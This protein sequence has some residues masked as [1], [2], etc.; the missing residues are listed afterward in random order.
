MFWTTFYVSRFTSH[1]CR[2]PFHVSRLKIG[3]KLNSTSRQCFLSYVRNHQNSRS[4]VSP[5]LPNPGVIKS[6]L[7]YLNLPYTEDD[8]QNEILLSKHL[9]YEPMF[10]AELTNL[11][12]NWQVDESRSDDQFEIS[13]IQTPKG[14]WL[15]RFPR[16]EIQWNDDVLCPVQKEKDHEFFVAVCEQVG[17]QAEKIRQYY[18]QFRQRVGED[19]VIVLGHPHPSWLGYQ[20]GPSMI[21]YHWNDF[22]ATF[23]R[24]M[25]TLFEASL[26]VMNIA[27]EEGIDFMSDSSYGLEM[28]SPRLFFE[29]DLPYIQKFAQWT[30]ERNGLFWYHNCGYTRKLIMDGT[31]NTLGADLIETIA[32]PPEGDN[33]LAE[34]R[35]YIDPNICTK[36]NLNL[37]LLRDGNPNQIAEMTKQMVESIRGWKHNFSTADAV[38]PGT[39]PENF[40]SFVRTARE[41]SE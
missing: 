15:R 37:N 41:A 14:E 23:I 29:M 7:G 10:M 17:D 36:G 27:M 16:K 6:T 11:I 24:S 32:P 22:R 40:I 2:L 34:S 25:D 21:F 31:F 26:F 20:I 8:I 18:R 4:I 38:L 33:D 35:K 9:D 5:F 19:G 3:E 39:P 13:A 30:H 1:V 28:T 12:F